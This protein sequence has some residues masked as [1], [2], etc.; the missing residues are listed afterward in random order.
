MDELKILLVEDNEHDA[1]FI[2]TILKKTDFSGR[3]IWLKD[4]QEFLDYI[5]KNPCH[6]VLFT[7]MDIKMPRLS[8]IETLQALGKKGGKKFPII[9]CSA[10]NQLSDLQKGMELNA[11]AFVIKSSDFEEF[12]ATIVDTYNFWGKRNVLLRQSEELL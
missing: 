9:L 5:D 3:L 6:D 7:L 12:T 10:S 1:F 8:G 4:G 11:N 2:N